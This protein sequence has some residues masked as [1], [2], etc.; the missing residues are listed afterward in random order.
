MRIPGSDPFDVRTA[1]ADVSQ[2][3]IGQVREFAPHRL[4]PGTCGY[5]GE[6]PGLGPDT[7]Q[8][9]LQDWLQDLPQGLQVGRR[10]MKSAG[11]AG[12]S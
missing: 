5:S 9:W 2:F 4:V 1:N 7:L 3:T 10:A 12:R 11:A 6:Q 8:D